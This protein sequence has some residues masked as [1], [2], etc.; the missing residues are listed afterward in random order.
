MAASTQLISY[1]G[2]TVLNP[3]KVKKTPYGGRIE[4]KW[5]FENTCR[6]GKLV[7]HLKDN[8]KVAKKK[9]WSQVISAL[10]P[11]PIPYSNNQFIII[12]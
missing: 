7:V 5:T 10:D 12:M 2:Q 11:I 9:R 4:W 6:P 8:E 1:K 3:P